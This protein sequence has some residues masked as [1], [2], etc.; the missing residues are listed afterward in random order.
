MSFVRRAEDVV[1]AKSLIK[2]AGK[3]YAGDREAG[4]ARGHRKSGGDSDC[5]DGVMVARGIWEWR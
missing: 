1:L 3:E 5:P 4:K 2:R